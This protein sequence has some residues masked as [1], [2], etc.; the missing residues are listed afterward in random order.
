MFY[1]D[2]KDF[3]ENGGGF[4]Q[5]DIGL[6]FNPD[7][8]IIG[9]VILHHQNWIAPDRKSGFSHALL[10]INKN[11][12]TFESGIKLKGKS[13]HRIGSQDLFKAYDGYKMMVIRHEEMTDKKFIEV[14]PKFSE[15]YNEMI[16]PYW[17]LPLYFIPPIARRFN[18]IHPVVCSELVAKFYTLIKDKDG[19]PFMRFHLGVY[20]DYLADMGDLTY[21]QKRFH[22]VFH[23]KVYHPV[24]GHS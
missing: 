8:R 5:G 15:E 1:T 23:G 3:Y 11:G 18:V 2:M 14:F 13:F 21:G 9:K 6:T 4:R 19:K 12:A 24:K 10:V 7:Q 17:R 20:P 22:I 16:Y